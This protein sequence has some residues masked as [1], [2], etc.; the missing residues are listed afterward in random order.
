MKPVG[1]IGFLAVCHSVRPSVHPSVRPSVS[2]SVS[3]LGVRPLGFPNFSQSFF[4]ILT[5]NLV[6]GFVLTQYW[7]SLTLVAFDLF[8]HELLPF[9]KISF[10]GLFFVI[11]WHI[12]L[13]FH[14]WICLDIIQVKFDFGRVWPTFTWV[15]ALCKIVVFRTFLCHLSTY[16][17]EISYMNLSWHNAGQVRLR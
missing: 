4:E 11:F 15:I 17:V 3:P 12:E 2:Q 13:K 7:S 6:Y 9:A 8:L 10:S 16:W 5:L 1:T 14:I